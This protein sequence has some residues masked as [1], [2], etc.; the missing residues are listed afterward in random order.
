LPF[1]RKQAKALLREYE[2]G[3]ESAVFRMA[4][5]IPPLRSVALPRKRLDET[6]Q[7]ADAQHVIARELGYAGWSALIQKFKLHR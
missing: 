7:L 2:R 3:E 1:L 6:V 4:T 5:M